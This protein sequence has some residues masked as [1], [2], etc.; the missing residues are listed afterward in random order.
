MDR[1][2]I[3][4]LPDDIQLK[5]YLMVMK[6][7][8]AEWKADHQRR[9]YNTLRLFPY[10]K[11]FTIVNGSFVHR[12]SLSGYQPI[13]G[14]PQMVTYWDISNTISFK[15]TTPDGEDS[16]RWVWNGEIGHFRYVFHEK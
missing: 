3:K 11:Y 9:F 12:S 13:P 7:H 4:Q 5:I 6:R 1:K 2:L 16:S 14:Q 8:N 10:S 15:I